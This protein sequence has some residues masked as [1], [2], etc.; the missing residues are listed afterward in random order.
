MAE[1]RD[2]IVAAQTEESDLARE[3]RKAEGDVDQVRERS[4]RDTKRM[5]A[6]QVS[7][8]KELQGLQHEI[9]TLAERQSALEDIV[10]DVMERLESVQSRRTELEEQQEK[11][12]A[13]SVAVTA[14]RDTTVGEI[15]AEAGQLAEQRS[16]QISAVDQALVDLYEKIRAQQGGVGAALLRER[17]CGGCRLEL[18][19]IELGRIRDADPDE[20]WR[21]E[22][23]RR[24]LV[25]TG[26]SGL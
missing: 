16:T 9:A 6:G 1:L 14:R 20:V 5:D 15:D 17:R 21:C 18:N 2:Q 24:I 11:A 10:L 23:C 19:N 22:E 3:L 26:E 25:R 4:E 7:S 8:P 12:R 13:E